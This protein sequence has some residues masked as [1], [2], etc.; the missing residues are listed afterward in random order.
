MRKLTMR[1]L[2]LA[3]IVVVLSVPSLWAG[4]ARANAGEAKG[5]PRTPVIDLVLNHAADLGLTA[6]QK[7][8]LE[9]L[10]EKVEKAREAARQD[11]AVQ[12]LIK[13][14]A[15]A[16]K[17]D[18]E[19]KLK[20]LREKMRELM[21]KGIADVREAIKGILTP[22]QAKKL[23]ELLGEQKGARGNKNPGGQGATPEAGQAPTNL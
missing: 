23:H 3:G 14:L 1:S 5:E 16:K 11:P 17:A 10:K 15:A 20:E 13:Q 12:D 8:Q 6:D 19:A 9:A 22:D 2:W 18:D 7:T 4:Q 21:S